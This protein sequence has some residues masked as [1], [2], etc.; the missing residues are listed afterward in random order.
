MV[1]P[2]LHIA[3]FQELPDKPDEM[4][5]LNAPA[6][7]V[8]QCMMVNMV[9]APLNVTLDKPFDPSKI[10]LH[11]LECRMTTPF[12]AK[13]VGCI[14]ESRLVD[15]L[16]YH[17]NHFLYQFIVEGGYTKGTLFAIGLGDICPAGRGGL[18]SEISQLSN[19][20]IDT[21][22]THTVHSLAICSGGHTALLGLYFLIRSQVKFGVIQITVETLILVI[23]VACF[24]TKTFQYILG[25]SH[26]VSHTFP[27][28]NW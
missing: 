3:R 14:Q 21:L 12:W 13:A 19:Q 26:G 23:A 5:I 20:R 1:N 4:L 27:F 18:V 7:D 6:Q 15:T 17:A 10:L 22:H 2:I 25:T 8:D 16:Q 11:M 28:V 9:K 24:G